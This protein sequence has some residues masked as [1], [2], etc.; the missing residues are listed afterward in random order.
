MGRGVVSGGISGPPILSQVIN[1]A[2]CNI[3]S[4]LTLLVMHINSSFKYKY[5]FL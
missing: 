4:L 3:R 1:S 5:S 2:L